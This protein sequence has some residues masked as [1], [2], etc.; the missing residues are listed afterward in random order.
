IIEFGKPTTLFVLAGY[1][2][3]RVIQLV[4]YYEPQNVIVGEC[5]Q[6]KS[7][8]YGTTNAQIVNID[9]YDTTWGCD[10]IEN[11]IKNILET[12]NLI[13]ASLGPKTGAISVYQCFIKYPQIALAYVPCKEFNIDYCNGIG[14]TLIKEINFR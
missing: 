9:E 2:E 5:N 3:E 4:N 7:F 1:D 14:D 6:R 12:S 8:E 13:V 11:K 10:T